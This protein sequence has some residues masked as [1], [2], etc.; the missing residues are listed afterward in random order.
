MTPMS[1]HHHARTGG[2]IRMRVAHGISEHSLFAPHERVVLAFSGGADSLAL[3][4]ILREL[5]ADGILSI[6]IV[7]A[8]M[9]H[10][11]RG[12]AAD[13]DLEFCR[14]TAD[15]C[16]LPFVSA[17]LPVEQL[18]EKGE[19][20]EQA[21]RRL[22]YDFLMQTAAAA[23][24]KKIA[25]GHHADDVAETLLMRMLR[26]CGLY[27]LA[28]MPPRRTL[29][30]GSDIAL[31]RPL[32]PVAKHELVAYLKARE[33][34]FRY[35]ESNADPRYRRNRIRNRLI[36]ELK[37]R[38]P[39]CGPTER[40]CKINALACEARAH[41]DALAAEAVEKALSRTAA[42]GVC[43]CTEPLTPLSRGVRIAA[44]RRV[45]QSLSENGGCAPALTR[46]HWDALD[47]LLMR[48]PGCSLSLPG[49]L[50]ARREHG[51]IFFF[52][53]DVERSQAAERPLPVPGR[54][55]PAGAPPLTLTASLGTMSE[56][57]YPPEAVE[58]EDR[59]C[60]HLDIDAVGLPLSVRTRRA[61]DR[62]HPLGAPGERKLKRFLIDRKIPLHR[63]D[64]IPLVL[65]A[66]GRIVWVAGEEI[67]D[68]CRVTVETKTIIE[69][70]ACSHSADQ[71]GV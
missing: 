29:Q 22:R 27:G 60:A 21:A 45:I 66:G 33:T 59:W 57:R 37:R 8:H 48:R 17:L 47:A 7:L 46:M 11:L 71:T 50:T 42:G 25:V 53:K 68:F 9:N 52:E 3:L 4:T 39:D 38:I 61:G 23:Q 31:V 24:A 67:A 65:D 34:G 41:L 58:R 1:A 35:D 26:G 14:D 12:T 15:A 63:R 44:F 36:P 10:G 30:Y 49:G 51:G 55:S 32:L 6:D 70:R 5:V 16:N 18:R 28:A 40:L 56:H 13:R 54:I 64:G 69:L 2:D 19:S 20:L 43:L 62:F